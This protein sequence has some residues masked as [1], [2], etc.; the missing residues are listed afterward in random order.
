MIGT[1]KSPEKVTVKGERLV[2]CQILIESDLC[3]PL[4][5]PPHT[6]TKKWVIA[7]GKRAARVS[8]G[9]VEARITDDPLNGYSLVRL[10]L[11]I[12]TLFVQKKCL[13]AGTQ[14]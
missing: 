13:I 10:G 4:Y 9:S 14:T 6:H 7:I 1:Q 5:P 8:I 11:L 12:E 3:H 2:V